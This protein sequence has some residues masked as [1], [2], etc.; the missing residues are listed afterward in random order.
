MARHCVLKNCPSCAA[1]AAYWYSYCETCCQS[2]FVKTASCVCAAAAAVYVIVT[3]SETLIVRGLVSSVH[4]CAS[5][6]HVCA[7]FVQLCVSASM[8]E[9]ASLLLAHS[10]MSCVQGSH[11]C[12]CE[13]QSDH[14]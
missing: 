8:S 13:H 7:S 11:R 1:A 6:V 10:A 12:F 5:V 2:V 3:L 4:L 14:Y 9:S